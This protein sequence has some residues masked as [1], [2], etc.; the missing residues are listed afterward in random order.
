MRDVVRKLSLR[1]GRRQVKDDEPSRSVDIVNSAV[2]NDSS[3]RSS[4][5][6]EEARGVEPGRKASSGLRDERT[7]RPTHLSFVALLTMK[8][9]PRP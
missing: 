7:T 3:R 5:G 1:S 4:K 9:L 6:D 8:A 2:K